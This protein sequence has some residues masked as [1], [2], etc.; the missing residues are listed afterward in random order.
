[1]KK[2]IISN[3]VFLSLGILV[4]TVS[5]RPSTA[6]QMS[7]IDRE[8]T[9]IILKEISGDIHKYYYDPKFHGVDWDTRIRQAKQAIDESPSIDLALARIADAID[10]LNDSHT[11]MLPPLRTVRPDY[12]FDY[13]MLGNRCFVTRVRPHSDA[14]MKGMKPGD[15]V[16]SID[17]FEPTRESLW[18]VH[19]KYEI[20]RPQ[21]FLHLQLRDLG[22]QQRELDVAAKVHQSRIVTSGDVWDAIRS[23]ETAEHLMRLQ[24]AEFGVDLLI[25]KFP[26][27]WFSSDEV[28]SMIDKARQHKALILDLRD[29]RGGSERTLTALVGGLFKKE[30]KIGDRVGRKE[31]APLTAKPM[32]HVYEG[33]LTILVDSNSASASELLARVIQIEQRGAVLGDHTEGSVMEAKHYTY[34]TG[35]YNVL[36]Y[37]A[38]I[39][40]ADLLLANG[41]SLEHVGVQPDDVLIP[42]AEALAKGE[43]P[44]LSRAAEQLGVKLNP[45]D[46]GKLFPYEWPPE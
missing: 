14:E 29:D 25:V 35:A 24:Y 12:G 42:S 16:L 19:Y 34:R 4:V 18:K 9:E 11:F 2:Q 22:G 32:R 36:S 46:A 3:S 38:S 5:V 7:R 20:L 15:E 45:A 27:F 41:K 1:M 17:G 10:S 30:V 13:Q 39:T 31:N 26:A 40:E 44:V 21:R 33:P 28:Q 8:R 23:R 43:D 6:Q 37:G